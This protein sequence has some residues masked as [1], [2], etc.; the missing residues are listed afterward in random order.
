MK[1]ITE[2]IEVNIYCVIGNETEGISE[3]FWIWRR[4]MNAFPW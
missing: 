2:I 4:K 3:Q 1:I